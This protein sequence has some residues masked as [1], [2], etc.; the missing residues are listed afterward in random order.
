MEIIRQFIGG[1]WR[2]PGSVVGIGTFDGVHVA[3]QALLRTVVERSRT[4]GVPS[5]VLTFDPHPMEVLRPG[6]AGRLVSTERK[7][8][9]LGRAGPD[10]AV[11]IAFSQ[12]FA[13]TEPEA[14]VEQV[15]LERLAAREIVVGFNFTFGYRARG[16]PTLLEALGGRHGFVTHVIPPYSLEGELVSSSAIRQMLTEGDVEGAARLLGR[17]YT[18]EGEVVRGAGRGRELGFPTA[19]LRA[20]PANAVVP[21]RGVYAGSAHLDGEPA[22]RCAINVGVSS[23][24][25]GSRQRVEVHLLDFEGDLLGKRLRV[26]F[27]RR[28][29]DERPFGSEA[30]LA[31][32]IRADVLA[33]RKTAPGRTAR[34]EQA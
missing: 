19:N 14:F 22:R 6:H 7:L 25:G 29:R 12:E 4:L 11:L 28:L 20:R 24:F 3:H 16:T 10:F 2:V 9:E 18:L 33:S 27:R 26:S 34:D 8:L 17:A 30:E 23:T 15:L 21:G 13:R 31:E 1:T 5:V 32:Q